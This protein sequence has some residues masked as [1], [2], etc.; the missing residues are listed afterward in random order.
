MPTQILV[1]QNHIHNVTSPPTS[2]RSVSRWKSQRA[3]RTIRALSRPDRPFAEEG[4][5]DEQTDG[6]QPGIQLVKRV[7]AHGQDDI[8]EIHL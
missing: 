5:A 1:P 4:D 2:G 3:G 8:H 7:S 6:R